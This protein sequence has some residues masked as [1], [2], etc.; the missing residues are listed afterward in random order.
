MPFRDVPFEPF[1]NVILPLGTEVTEGNNDTL[2]WLQLESSKFQG[3]REYWS[4]ELQVFKPGK[5][6]SNIISTS[7]DNSSI[8]LPNSAVDFHKER[9]QSIIKEKSRART[10]LKHSGKKIDDGILILSMDKRGRSFVVD[11]LK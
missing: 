3:I 11:S 8:F 6:Y 7:A 9:V 2:W 10:S 4:Y 1:R 5:T